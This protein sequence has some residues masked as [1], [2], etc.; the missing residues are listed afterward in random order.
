MYSIH[1]QPVYTVQ[2]IPSTRCRKLMDSYGDGGQPLY[3]IT[4]YIVQCTIYI[5]QCTVYDK[6]CTHDQSG[7]GTER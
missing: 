2:C 4:L 1:S 7:R 6:L 3:G 5:V